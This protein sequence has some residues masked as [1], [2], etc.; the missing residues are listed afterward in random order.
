MHPRSGVR[1]TGESHGSHGGQGLRGKVTGH[2][3]METG[4]TASVCGDKAA[5]GIRGVTSRG[6]CW[7]R[8]PRSASQRD[9]GEGPWS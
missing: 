2:P 9:S 8:G 7:E 4:V 5:S 6:F 3:E 1:P